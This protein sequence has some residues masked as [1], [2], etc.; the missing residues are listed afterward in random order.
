MSS[1]P[2]STCANIGSVKS[3]ETE[4][5]HNNDP[6]SSSAS[7]ASTTATSDADTSNLTAERIAAYTT[8]PIDPNPSYT[9]TSTEASVAEHITAVMSVVDDFDAVMNKVAA[10]NG[11]GS[12][13]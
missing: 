7:S 12:E 4:S 1:K 5:V 10:D 3:A 13:E 11:E 9:N 2:S 8:N 6:T